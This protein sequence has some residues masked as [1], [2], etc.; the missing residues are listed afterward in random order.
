MPTNRRR[1]EV[2]AVFDGRPRRLALT[3]GALAE[4]EDAFGAP[5]LVALAERFEAGRLSARDVALILG[6]GLRGGGAE[7]GDDDVARMTHADGAAG[8]VRV[9]A[10]LLAAT[11]GPAGEGGRAEA[12]GPFPGT[13]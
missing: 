9:V 13:S 7:T 2:E 3:L 10:D 5:D 4:L 12:S 6:A 11:F 1:G 8:F